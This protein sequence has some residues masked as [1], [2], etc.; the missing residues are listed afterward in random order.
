MANCFWL[1][2]LFMRIAKLAVY[3]M[4]CHFSTPFL[5]GLPVHIRGPAGFQPKPYAAIFQA[6]VPITTHFP[7]FPKTL[8][9][10][11][12]PISLFDFLKKICYYK[13]KKLFSS[14]LN[15]LFSKLS[16]SSTRYPQAPSHL[17]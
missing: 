9:T 7:S 1:T 12:G 11:Q 16:N 2:Q 6:K 10:C 8:F 5:F 4:E 14:P 3:P 15:S 17:R 13:N